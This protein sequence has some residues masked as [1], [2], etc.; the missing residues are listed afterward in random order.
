MPR[1]NP[2]FPASA[3]AKL[4]ELRAAKRID[5]CRVQ[6]KTTTVDRGGAQVE[7]WGVLGDP[8]PC[9]VLPSNRA[10]REGIRGGRV[11]PEADVEIRFHRDVVVR[12]DNRITHTESGQRFDVINDPTTV[13]TGLELIVEGK[14]SDG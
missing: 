9:R 2:L 10:A 13:T 12:R 11:S 8:I 3:I 5:T 7:T 6:T 1:P 4:D 14:D